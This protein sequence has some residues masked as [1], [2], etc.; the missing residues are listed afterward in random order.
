MRKEIPKGYIKVEMSVLVKS[1]KFEEFIE[2][3]KR[4][5]EKFRD[6]T[7]RPGEVPN[8]NRRLTDYLNRQRTEGDQ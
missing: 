7:L 3:I 2:E 8:P 1:E 4:I 6:F 5:A